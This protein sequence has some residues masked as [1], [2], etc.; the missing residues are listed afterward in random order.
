MAHRLLQ[1]TTVVQFRNLDHEMERC[2]L[3]I[4]VPPHAPTT[5]GPSSVPV[6]VWLLDEIDE[7]IPAAGGWW[8]EP[9]PRHKRI[10]TLPV[11]QD[12]ASTSPEFGCASG[13]FTTIELACAASNPDCRV[14][15]WQN[16]MHHPTAG[17]YPS[18]FLIMRPSIAHFLIGIYMTQF[19]TSFE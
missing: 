1:V 2:A 14:A 5:G 16:S 19:P 13:S 15:F 4:Q 18:H 12:A 3:S 6:D 10:A 8:G 7:L 17:I 11:C 9:P